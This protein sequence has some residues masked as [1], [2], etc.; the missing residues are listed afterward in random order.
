MLHK[1]YDQNKEIND[2]ANIKIAKKE[3]KRKLKKMTTAIQVK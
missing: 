3:R 2:D 1:V